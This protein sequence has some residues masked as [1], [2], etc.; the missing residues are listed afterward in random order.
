[1]RPRRG[2]GGAQTVVFFFFFNDTAT[3][4][5]YTLSL[6]D[7][8]PISPSRSPARAR[9]AVLRPWS[10]VWAARAAMAAGAWGR[11]GSPSAPPAPPA[12]TW[13]LGL[14][15]WGLPPAASARLPRLWKGAGATAGTSWAVARRKGR[16][17]GVLGHARFHVG[18][19][20]PRRLEPGRW[21]FGTGRCRRPLRRDSAAFGRGRGHAR[22]RRARWRRGRAS[23][24]GR[25]RLLDLDLVIE[26]WLEGQLGRRRLRFARHRRLE[27]RQRPHLVRLPFPPQRPHLGRLEPY[28]PQ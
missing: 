28:P 10:C 8:L 3:T 21:R 22:E 7:A 1:M 27:L 16:W 20:R 15:D 18:P 24:G 14:L 2:P 26:Q 11:P 19:R 25:P 5:I 6:H 17:G 9:A 12:G 13:G 23:R 4:E